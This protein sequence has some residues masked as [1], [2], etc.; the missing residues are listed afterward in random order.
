MEIKWVSLK[1]NSTWHIAIFISVLAISIFMIFPSNLL[2]WITFIN[3]LILL[4][5]LIDQFLILTNSDFKISFG[6]NLVIY[7][8]SK[9]H[10][11]FLACIFLLEFF[12]YPLLFVCIT[13]LQRK[14]QS[15]KGKQVGTRAKSFPQSLEQSWSRST[16]PDLFKAG[17]E[18]LTF[19]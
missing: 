4:I 9:F 10:P 1:Q 11:Y 18:P 7:K 6:T 17:Q 16:S 14:S 19:T 13:L 15:R 2:M 8:C 12:T 3:G 5:H